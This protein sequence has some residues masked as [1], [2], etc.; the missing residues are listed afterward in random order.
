MRPARARSGLAIGLLAALALGGCA[1]TQKS[2]IVLL[3]DEG[4]PSASVS[5]TNARGS[6]V[7][8]KPGQATEIVGPNKAPGS[9]VTLDPAT[10]ER[11]FGEALAAMPPPPVRFVLSFEL[12]STELT[13]E[14]RARLP[15]ILAVVAKR[16]PAEVSV[17]GHTDT[18]GPPERNY[19]LGLERAQ[20]VADLL[21]SL[22]VTPAALEISSHGEADLLIPT[23][24]EIAEPQNRR[25]DVTVR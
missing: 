5:V 2:V 15:E 20:A 11:L 8:T 23:G 12:D 1:S 21:T 9:P 16:Q 18:V 17:V 25:V 10:I 19:R 6:Q 4:S 14:S 24:D 13:P 3:A 22:G 7:L